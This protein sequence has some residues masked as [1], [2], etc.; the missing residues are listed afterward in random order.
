MSTPATVF[1]ASASGKQP[2][3]VRLGAVLGA[4]A[5][6]GGSAI[7][8]LFD[9]SRANFYPVC[10][11][12]A[13]TGLACPGCGLTRSFH[14]L[15][16]GDILTALDLNL[17]SPVWIVIFGWVVLSLLLLGVRGRGLKMWPTEPRFLWT[18]LVVMV[19][20]AVVRNI[21]LWPLSILYP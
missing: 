10:P 19:V 9:P 12:Y 14:S 3:C 7:V 2:L 5:I 4:G 15:F 6:V 11:L 18:F 20:F 16:H 13:L 8:A 1:Q 17:L 21:P